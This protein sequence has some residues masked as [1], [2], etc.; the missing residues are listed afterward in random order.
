[1]DNIIRGAN[2][3]CEEINNAFRTDEVK[4]PVLTRDMTEIVASGGW[5]AIDLPGHIKPLEAEMDMNG[6]HSNLRRRFGREPGD[7][8][9]VTYYENL[10]D[11]FP[12]G[13]NAGK[14]K[15]KGRTVIMKGLL[16]EVSQSGVKGVKASGTTKLKWGTIYL[17]HDLVDGETVHKMNAKTNTLIING[18]NYTAEHNRLLRI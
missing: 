18:V 3:Y 4:L 9:T 7:W 16:N 11:I 13:E 8:T 15:L 14:P 6:S 17:Y 12:T 2:W 5:F 10:I 1:M